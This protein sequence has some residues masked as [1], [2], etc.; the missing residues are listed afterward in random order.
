M[1][2]LEDRVFEELS[3]QFKSTNIGNFAKLRKNNLY[4]IVHK[5][6][7]NEYSEIKTTY[8]SGSQYCLRTK[9]DELLATVL[10][11]CV[12]Q[13]MVKCITMERLQKINAT[14]YLHSMY[15]TSIPQ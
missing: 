3:F 2:Q 1:H 14:V 9:H 10:Y 13:E 12:Q 8:N 5:P 4:S 15:S 7:T 11:F 6:N